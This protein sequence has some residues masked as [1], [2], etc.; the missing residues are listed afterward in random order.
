MVCQGGCD[1]R[2]EPSHQRRG[3]TILCV[4]FAIL[5]VSGLFSVIVPPDLRFL[6]ALATI[7]AFFVGLVYTI[8]TRRED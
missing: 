8:Q 1:N 7:F 5:F 6:F 4:V 3:E 2:E